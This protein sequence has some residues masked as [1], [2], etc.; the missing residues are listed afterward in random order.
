MVCVHVCVRSGRHYLIVATI[1]SHVDRT[2]DLLR[3]NGPSLPVPG[4][5][6]HVRIVALVVYLAHGHGQRRK[7][8]KSP[9][10]I[11]HP[12]R[13]SPSSC[14]NIP[15]R[16]AS[17]LCSPLHTV[18]AAAPAPDRHRERGTDKTTRY[19]HRHDQ[20]SRLLPRDHRGCVLLLHHSQTHPLHTHT[21]TTQEAHKHTHTHKRHATPHQTLTPIR[22]V[23]WYCIDWVRLGTEIGESAP[24]LTSLSI[25]PKR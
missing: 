12:H 23:D 7:T 19:R 14:Y 15:E 21:G 20:S 16:S 3:Y 17:L 24:H 18:T 13:S 10:P 11:Q 9:I 2:L 5:P 1:G 6:T 8:P 25:H 4:P 22:V